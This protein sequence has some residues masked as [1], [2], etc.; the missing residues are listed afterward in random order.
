MPVQTSYPGV[1]VEERPSGVRT[2]VG[3]STSVTAFVGSSRFG[4]TTEPVRV[5]SMAD[6]VRRFGPPVSAEAP[7]GHMVAQYFVNGGSEAIIVRVVASRRHDCDG[8]APRGHA[9]RHARARRRERRNV[10]H[11]DRRAR[12][13]RRGRPCDVEPERPVQPRTAVPIHRS[14]DR[15]RDTHCGGALRERL[16]V[17]GASSIDPPPCSP[18][19][20]S[21]RW[22]RPARRPPVPRKVSPPA[23][24]SR[25]RSTST[26]PTT[27]CESPSTSVHPSIWS[28]HTGVTTV[29]SSAPRSR[30]P[31]T[32]PGSPS[33]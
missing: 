16:D 19:R 3:V 9:R 23:P 33:P 28:S 12:T 10:G 6:Y 4:P 7:M 32:R 8:N 26:A 21:S 5:T 18:T 25:R 27:G 15:Q 13:G 14:R 1:Y 22:R 29:V 31:R 24:H 17:A 20:T 2:I 30:T 11:H